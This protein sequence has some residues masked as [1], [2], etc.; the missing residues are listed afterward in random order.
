MH[1]LLFPNFLYYFFRETY[2]GLNTQMKT[3]LT[4]MNLGKFLKKL[5]T[6]IFTILFHSWVEWKVQ[7]CVQMINHSVVWLNLMLI[8]M[9][10]MFSLW[11]NIEFDQIPFSFPLSSRNFQGRSSQRWKH[12]RPILVNCQIKL[13]NSIITS[14][15]SKCALWWNV[16][17]KTQRTPVVR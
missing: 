15:G 6:M 8:L 14:E 4:L 10:V 11:V 1:G 9:A 16:T 17:Q 13:N 3:M 12:C 2:L 7:R 5:C